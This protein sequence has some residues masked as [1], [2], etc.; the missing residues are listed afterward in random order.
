M[1]IKKKGKNAYKYTGYDDEEFGDSATAGKARG[2]LSKYD[3][4]IGETSGPR[5]SDGGFR[6]GSNMPVASTSRSAATDDG[7]EEQRQLNR[8]L[9]T[10]DYTSACMSAPAGQKPQG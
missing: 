8:D 3:A 9:L 1:D 7:P 2:I 4:V 6:L 10:L 5:A